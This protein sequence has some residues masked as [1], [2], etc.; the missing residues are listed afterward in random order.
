MG[1]KVDFLKLA[2]EFG[3]FKLKLFYDDEYCTSYLNNMTH[4]FEDRNFNEVINLWCH[5]CTSKFVRYYGVFAGAT[6]CSQCDT[7]M[8]FAVNVIYPLV[9]VAK[10]LSVAE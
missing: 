4:A 7:M 6:E 5:F 3:L 9:N 10:T 8:N 2:I 1:L